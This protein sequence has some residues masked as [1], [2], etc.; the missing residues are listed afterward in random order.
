MFPLRHNHQ[1]LYSE[2]DIRA[3][4]EAQIRMDANN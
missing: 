3:V 1:I 4:N 2:V